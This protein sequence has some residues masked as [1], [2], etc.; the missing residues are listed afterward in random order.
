MRISQGANHSPMHRLLLTSLTLLVLSGCGLKPLQ[1][2]PPDELASAPAMPVTGR[3]GWQMGRELRFGDF[4]TTALRGGSVNM[5]SASCPTGCTR[6]ALGPYV[7]QVDEASSKSRS[8][9]SFTLLAPLG[10]EAEVRAVGELGQQRRES[11]TRWFG[12]STETSQELSRSISFIGTIDPVPAEIP[13][14]RFEFRES[15]PTTGATSAYRGWAEDERG[16]RLLMRSLSRW[17]GDDAMGTAFMPALHLGY[18][19]ELDGR[20]VAAV[21]TATGGTVWMS[22]GL[23]PDL[24]LVIAGLAMALLARADLSSQP[25]PAL[26]R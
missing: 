1:V 23:A 14:W 18:A 15:S 12:V 20:V 19:F 3:Q 6:L 4:S 5:R 8:R 25:A 22:A 24:R 10:V 26:R 17:Q 16:R 21:D 2:R 13:G 11:L 9:L 7:K